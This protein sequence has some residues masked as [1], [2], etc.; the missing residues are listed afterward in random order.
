MFP[1]WGEGDLM[2]AVL[3]NSKCLFWMRLLVC[4][5]L[6]KDTVYKLKLEPD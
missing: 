6:D 2:N 1:L 4:V 3:M 5:P